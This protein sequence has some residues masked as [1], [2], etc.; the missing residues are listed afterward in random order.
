MNSTIRAILSRRLRCDVATASAAW[1]LAMMVLLLP[2]APGASGA[3]AQGTYEGAEDA[4]PASA[5]ETTTTA[6][7]AAEARSIRVE[8][9]ITKVAYDYIDRALG[10]AED[11]GAL[12]LVELSTPGGDTGSM[13]QITE[14]FLNAEVPVVVWVGPRGAQAASAGTFV[15]LAAH[16]AGMAP[17]TVIGAASPVGAGGEDLGET[18]LDKVTEDLAAV[19]RNLADDRGEEAVEW[20]EAAVREAV[21]ATAEEALELG[22]IDAVADDPA[23]LLA[24]L[25]GRSIEVAG[26]EATI[27]APDD[28][29][30]APT[31]IPMNQA[32]RLLSLLVQ[33][34]IAL[35]LLTLGANALLIE[36]SNPGGYIAGV[37]G[38]L[39]LVLGFYSLGALEA[40]LVGLAFFVVAIV[41]FVLELQAPTKGL[42]IVLGALLFVLGSV[43]LFAE[44]AF[45]VPWV[46]VIGLTAASAL[47]ALFVLGAIWRAL[48]RAPVTGFEGMVGREAEVKRDL[49]P[50]GKVLIDGELWEAELVAEGA[51]EASA[52]EGGAG[53]VV[54]PAEPAPRVQAGEQV[55]VL[56]REGYTL[57]VRRAD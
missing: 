30:I 47:F 18:M 15:V 54:L 48:K 10:V 8:G 3:F 14:R 38:V 50:H 35:L 4:A 45:G 46:T 27:R 17:S 56:G 34:A 26:A 52:G 43:I 29:A 2:L 42:F 36:L 19:A 37:I 40:N 6:Y 13:G 57:R 24:A 49:D 12:L 7:P 39:A 51:R 32:E 28:G 22:V 25:D 55:V 23:S 11:E 16:A 41:L 20:A 44:T 9:P 1:G 5:A 53:A 33:P 31:P 21:S